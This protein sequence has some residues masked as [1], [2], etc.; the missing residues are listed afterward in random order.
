MTP[1]S[2][3]TTAGIGL[4]R[5][6]AVLAAVT[7]FMENLDGTIIATA[8]PAIAADLGTQ[9][10]AINAAMTSYLVT[11]AVGIPVSGWLTDRFGARRVFLIA[12][13]LFTLASL[14]CAVSV[15]LPMLCLV[16][17]LQGVGGS[18]MVPVGRL[19]VLR[20]TA[21]KD[22]LAATAYLTWPA[23][24]APVI[25]PTLGGWLSSYASWHWIFL[26]NIPIGIA[27]FIAAVRLVH[28]RP[29]ASVPPLDWIGFLLC[30][31][32]LAAL[33]LGMERIGDGRRG[34]DLAV[35]IA[36]LIIAFALGVLCWRGLR[37][38]PNPLLDL[39]A[40]RVPTFRVVNS[41]GMVYRMAISAAPFLLPLMFQIGYGWSA[42]RAG[43]F[44][45]ALFAGNVMIK[46]ATSPLIRRF[47]F[48]TVVVGSSLG[49]ALVFA[50]CGLI[51]ADSPTWL[52]VG[53]LFASGVFRSIG[54][55]GY[56][57][58]QF[59][60]IEIDQMAD[61]NTLSSTIQQIAAGLGVA[62]GALILRGADQLLVS[63]APDAGPQAGFQIAFFVLALI[64][65]YPVLEGVFGLHRHAGHEVAHGH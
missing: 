15:N 12:I 4:N 3:Q 13:A 37:R 34:V 22:L 46:P 56:N 62:F 47:G 38:R 7:F 21:K 61:A 8:A 53:L 57:S 54:F 6:L 40:M 28:D 41:S 50:A 35:S 14:L 43:L 48:R 11:L 5:P 17:I 63:A 60:D 45:M 31:G 65:L 49:G 42:A 51:T 33:L 9:P 59:A 24:L 27:C 10:V 1:A 25:A 30:G 19:V 20:N 39:T 18:M 36:L 29:A 16:R 52:I 64:M 44:V 58:L 32:S 23:L 2:Q 55:S 26:I